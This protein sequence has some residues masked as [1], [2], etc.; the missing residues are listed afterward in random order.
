MRV[1]VKVSCLLACGLMLLSPL[2]VGAADWST[3]AHDPQRSGWAKEE[4]AITPENVSGLELKWKVHLK[5]EAKF[6]S[7]LT[8]PVVASGVLTSEGLK[9]MVYVAASRDWK[10]RLQTTL[11]LAASIP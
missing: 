5:N 10:M 2:A 11:P 7:A 9:T 8:A 6:L 4:R 1:R 3:F